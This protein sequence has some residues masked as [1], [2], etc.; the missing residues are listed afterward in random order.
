[1]I[2]VVTRSASWAAALALALLPGL[3][4]AQ[5]CDGTV[6]LGVLNDMSSLD[7][8]TTGPGSVVA[9]LS[10]PC[11]PSRLRLAATCAERKRS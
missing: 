9:T 7:Q 2:G 8:D 3:G 11:R 4:A 10:H 1:M 6:K 5:G